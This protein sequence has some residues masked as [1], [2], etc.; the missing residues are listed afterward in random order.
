MRWFGLESR[1]VERK[2]VLTLLKAENDHSPTALVAG[3][4][5]N[6]FPRKK[7]RLDMMF[8]MIVVLDSYSRRSLKFFRCYG[9]SDTFTK[10]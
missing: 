6:S 5:S 9:L 10:T 4:T 3:M 7:F 2:Y 8:E 1:I